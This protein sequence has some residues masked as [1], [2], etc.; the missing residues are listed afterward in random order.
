MSDEII[1]GIFTLLGTILG[2]SL[3]KISDIITAK[4]ERRRNQLNFSFKLAIVCGT[5]KTLKTEVNESK[6]I[7][8]QCD[9]EKIRTILMTLNLKDELSKLDVLFEKSVNPNLKNPEIFAQFGGLNILA[10]N[11]QILT[12]IKSDNFQDLKPG[13]LSILSEIIII[14]EDINNKMYYEHIKTYQLI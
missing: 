1:I 6:K 2:F 7:T 13:L 4:R 3:T 9:L 5:M 8:N 11:L 12:E 10:N 14:I